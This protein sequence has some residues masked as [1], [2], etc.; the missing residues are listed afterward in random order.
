MIGS[1]GILNHSWV[2]YPEWAIRPLSTTIEP[3]TEDDAHELMA[4]HALRFSTPPF[5]KGADLV[6]LGLARK[7][8]ATLITCDESLLRYGTEGFALVI[9]PSTWRGPGSRVL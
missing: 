5:V 3:F 4:A 6:Y 7:H 2:L 9:R 1:S 8:G